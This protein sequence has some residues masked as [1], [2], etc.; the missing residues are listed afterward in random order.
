[1]LH[2]IYNLINM[3]LSMFLYKICFCTFGKTKMAQNNFNDL[4]CILIQFNSIKRSF[5]FISQRIWDSFFFFFSKKSIFLR[6][7]MKMYFSNFEY[8]ETYLMEVNTLLIK[9]KLIFSYFRSPFTYILIL[10]LVIHK[11]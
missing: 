1:M 11:N 3:P 5:L 10:K 8:Y 4:K 6:E 9:T 2:N 7:K